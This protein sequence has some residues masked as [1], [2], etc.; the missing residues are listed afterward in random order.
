MHSGASAKQ[1]KRQQKEK[2]QAKL[3][4]KRLLGITNVKD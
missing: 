2:V 4:A 3:H 1:K